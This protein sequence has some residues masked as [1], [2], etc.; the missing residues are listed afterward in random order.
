MKQHNWLLLPL[1]ALLMFIPAI[2]VQAQDNT[3]PLDDEFIDALVMMAVNHDLM[4]G[5]NELGNLNAL[6]D[7]VDEYYMG[8]IMS[9]LDADKRVWIEE[10]KI[11]Q[12]QL[13]QNRIDKVRTAL[14]ADIDGFMK[15]FTDARKLSILNKHF[16]LSDSDS[17]PA[18][19]MDNLNVQVDTDASD[20]IIVNLDAHT[21]SVMP[22]VA[23]GINDNSGWS[24]NVPAILNSTAGM[25]STGGNDPQPPSAP[26]Q[27]NY[28]TQDVPR[29]KPIRFV[30]NGF[31][32]VTVVVESYEPAPAL[33]PYVP[34]ASTVVNPESNSSAYLNLPRGTY[35][36]C[37]YWQLEQDYNND[38]YFDYHHRATGTYTLDEN[39]SSNVDLAATVTLSPDSTVSNPNGKCGEVVAV[40]NSDLTPEELANQ[41]THTYSIYYHAPGT[42]LH[43]ETSTV[44]VHI[45]FLPNGTLQMGADGEEQYILSHAG[46][47][48]YTWLD[49]N[50][51][52][53]TY[54]FTMDGFEIQSK[55]GTGGEYV[56]ATSLC[57]R[58]D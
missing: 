20:L 8:R 21:I 40:D 25:P 47:N 3:Q 28:D 44:I 1:I 55:V 19:Y 6:K 49:D 26:S 53:Q 57:T 52:I 35:T 50:G 4:E 15:L 7:V 48:T 22:S 43:E 5:R 37:Y 41:G 2:S 58:Q 17:P 39:S 32:P 51:N 54:S 9:G 24:Y 27:D 10:Q 18:A 45:L 46:H 12:R 11:K 31:D 34:D 36:F 13:I 14:L 33:S 38:D 16:G 30:N 56:D 42:W 29:L 23:Q